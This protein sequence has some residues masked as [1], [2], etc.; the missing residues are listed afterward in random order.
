MHITH[1]VLLLLAS[2]AECCFKSSSSSQSSQ[3]AQQ[4]H[5]STTPYIPEQLRLPCSASEKR[6]ANCLNRGECFVIILTGVR[7]AYCSCTPEWMG[8]QC[9]QHFFQ[10]EVSQDN[11]KGAKIGVGVG[12]ALGCLLVIAVIVIVVVCVRRKRSIKNKNPM[13]TTHDNGST[14]TQPSAASF[15]VTKAVNG[16]DRNGNSGLHDA[17]QPHGM[18]SDPYY[19]SDEDKVGDLPS[20][21]N[22]FYTIRPHSQISNTSGCGALGIEK[23]CSG[24][25]HS[26]TSNTSGSGAPGLGKPNSG[27]P[28]SQMSNTSGSGAPTKPNG[29]LYRKPFG[30]VQNNAL[31]PPPLYD[32]YDHN[33]L[34]C[35]DRTSNVSTRVHE[36]SV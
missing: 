9:E 27:R 30:G 32:S 29:S 14:S 22:G 28:H 20:I 18:P 12:V 36:T 33:S 31:A 35:S 1:L 2:T 21:Q 17:Q 25:P 34:A 3:A 26:Q 4:Q 15:T 10:W 16:Y 6:T 11:N 5:Q 19:D 13:K 8:V 23:P 24:R 7:H